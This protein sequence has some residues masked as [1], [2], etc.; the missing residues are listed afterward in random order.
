[1]LH[2]FFDH[3]SPFIHVVELLGI[4]TCAVML[5]HMAQHATPVA[6]WCLWATVLIEFM[7]IR[8]C[9]LR[10]WHRGGTRGSGIGLQFKK[11]VS[12][13]AYLLFLGSLGYLMMPSL[14]FPAVVAFL[15]AIIAHVNVILVYL[16]HRDTSPLPINCF[17]N[18]NNG[19]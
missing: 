8:Y 16:A 12:A 10:R 7:F 4:F 2:F 5:G 13:N 15:L 19:K 9:A 1:M 17:S 6:A 3:R 11:A 14:V 18:Q